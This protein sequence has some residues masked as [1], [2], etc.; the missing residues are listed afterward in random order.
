MEML[1]RR[2]RWVLGACAAIAA[3]LAVPGVA[4]AKVE[5]VRLLDQCDPVTFNAAFGANFCQRTGSGVSL[6]DFREDINPKTFGH[7]AWWINASGGRNGT[8]KIRAGDVLRVANEGGIAHSFTELPAFGP[9]CIP[10]FSAP[11]GIGVRPFPEC[12]PLFGTIVA[13]GT[14]TDVA[15]LSVGTHR[16]QCIFHPWMRQ[17]VEVRPT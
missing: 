10:D 4:S 14:S 8:T 11:L 3:C 9:G 12:L 5:N 15:N 13:Q 2:A 17:S 6:E 7:R 1:R 16:F